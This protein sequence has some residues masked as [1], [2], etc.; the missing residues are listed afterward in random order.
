MKITDER[1][2][3][4]KN[5]NKQTN[6]Q[7]QKTTRGDRSYSE[8][9]IARSFCCAFKVGFLQLI[10]KISNLEKSKVKVSFIIYFKT[11]RII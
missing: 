5:R 6:K 1:E 3:K 11:K 9:V 4:R 10:C 8:S 7:R 2:T